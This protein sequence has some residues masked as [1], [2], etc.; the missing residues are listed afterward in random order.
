MDI[1]QYLKDNQS[2]LDLDFTKASQE[3]KIAWYEC[4]KKS[5]MIDLSLGH[6]LQHNQSARISVQ[7]SDC[8]GAR[9]YLNSEPI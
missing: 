1:K 5:T 8:T 3:A 7:L 9:D 6:C 2:V 4:L